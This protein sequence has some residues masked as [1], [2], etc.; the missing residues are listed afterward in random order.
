MTNQ[1]HTELQKDKNCQ[2][3]LTILET[4]AAALK[5]TVAQ[6]QTEIARRQAIEAELRDSAARFRTLFEH[7]PDGVF[8][9][10]EAGVILDVNRAA[11]TLYN[12]QP[13]TL[14]GHNIYNLTPLAWREEVAQ[15]FTTLLANSQQWMEF[16]SVDQ[17]LRIIPIETH[18]SHIEYAGQP[19]L[20]VHIRDISERLR[21]EETLKRRNRD[22]QLLNQASHVFSSS[23][24]LDAVL[25][26]I[27]DQVRQIMGVRAASIWLVDL[28]AEIVICRESSEQWLIRGQ[29]LPL[30]EGIV[31]WTIQHGQSLIVPDTRLDPRHYKDIDKEIG[32]EIR[33]I[34]SVPLKVKRHVVGALQV[35]DTE[36]DSFSQ[37]DIPIMEALAATAAIAIENAQLFA[38]V[39]RDAETKTTLLHE[40]NHRVKNNL[41]SII[42]LLY[43]QQNYDEGENRRTLIQDLIGRIQGI[44]QVHAMLSDTEWAP[45]PLDELTRQIVMSALRALPPGVNV[46]INIT[47]SRVRIA[48]RH[49]TNMALIINELTANTLKHA[50]AGRTTAE[51]RVRIEAEGEDRVLFAFSNDGPNYPEDVVDLTHHNLGL[52]L[53]KTLTERGL[54]GTL[55]LHNDNGPVTTIRFRNQ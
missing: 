17:D 46:A 5:Q 54:D 16:E 20:L 55:T 6:L 31:G 8:V 13:E 1:E 32:V 26:A 39:L 7:A 53:V 37:E 10:D 4:D 30:G 47:P 40:I 36:V 29:K 51:I 14:I 38:Q 48:S 45:L 41:T 24:D 23:L 19:A 43:S 12:A 27:L 44:A 15:M 3:S 2:E 33:C 21:A 49:A 35:V 28:R 50:L 22:L 9:M 42:G 34:L 25:V 11:C 18:L 52:Y